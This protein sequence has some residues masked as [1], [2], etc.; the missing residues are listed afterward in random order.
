MLF[1]YT[2]TLKMLSANYNVL[3]LVVTFIYV[4]QIA[5]QDG[6]EVEWYGTSDGEIYD[7]ISNVHFKIQTPL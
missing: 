1:V 4:L 7:T 2:Y 6:A 3:F 5:K